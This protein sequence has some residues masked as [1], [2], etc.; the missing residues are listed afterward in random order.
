MPKVTPAHEAEVRERIVHAAVEVFAEK[1]YH[2]ATIA[3]VVTRSGLSVG[4]IYTHFLNKEELFVRSCD[5]ISGRGL[6]VLAGRLASIDG[7]A[8]RL[9]AAIAYYVET[10]DEFD[11]EVGQISLVRAWAEADGEPAVREMLARR[12]ERL[13]ATAQMLL[14][15]GIARGDL[16]TWLDVEAFA[17]A[18]TGLMDGLL[19]QRLE[20]GP[21]YRPAEAL[22]RARTVLDILMAAGRAERA[23]PASA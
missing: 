23:G 17:R 12:R 3:E 14:H 22:R 11:G 10:I 18:Y 8:E 15:E 2:R 21:D 4:A 1:G 13:V 7:T 16:P 20:A 9:L 6:D 5:L 19:L